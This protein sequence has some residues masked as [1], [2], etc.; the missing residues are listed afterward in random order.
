MKKTLILSC[1]ILLILASFAGCEA[2]RS[3]VKGKTAAGIGEKAESEK[4]HLDGAE[5]EYVSSSSE[6]LTVRIENRT[7]STWQSG[8]MKDY[9]LEAEKDGEWYTVTPI[10]EIANTLELMLF[11]PGEK[12]THT[13]EFVERYGKLMPGKYRVVKSYWANATENIAAGEFYLVCEFTVE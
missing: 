3:F 7:D 8:N 5:M 4:T 6:S 12:L 2:I 10:K 13:F 1:A 11:A 9:Q